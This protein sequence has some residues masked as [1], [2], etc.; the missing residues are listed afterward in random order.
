MFFWGGE[1]TR[2]ANSKQRVLNVFNTDNRLDLIWW[3]ASSWSSSVKKYKKLS[4]V[5][6]RWHRIWSRRLCTAC[7]PPPRSP[8]CTSQTWPEN[9]GFLY[10]L[11]DRFIYIQYIERDLTLTPLQ[12]R[13]L[14][15]ISMFHGFYISP[16][17][18]THTKLTFD[19]RHLK[20]RPGDSVPL[21]SLSSRRLKEYLGRQRCMKR[22]RLQSHLIWMPMTPPC[23]QQQKHKDDRI[24][25]NSTL[26]QSA[27]TGL[28][29]TNSFLI[30]QI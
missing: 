7:A 23:G 30:N 20:L 21:P 3:A 2:H 26:H 9:S 6:T 15:T 14:G 27:F 25:E 22:S 17:W 19:P 4:P 24:T 28:W 10:R 18:S 29:W 8:C 1:E 11:L 13:V 16:D 5:Q 12:Q